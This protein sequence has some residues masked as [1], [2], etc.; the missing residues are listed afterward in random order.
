MK[1]IS[2]TFRPPQEEIITL[3]CEV[4]KNF[5]QK[6]KGLMDREKLENNTGMI[7]L[8]YFPWLR[9]FWMKNVKIP[10]DLIFVDR[11][12]KVLNF[13]EASV[14]SGLILYKTY[15]SHGFCKYVIECNIGFCKKNKIGKGTKISI[16]K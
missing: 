14:E 11:N 8:F 12:F 10:L 5:F 13:C 9:G 15:W 16:K 2:V 4:A 7:F 1:K 3:E 6:M